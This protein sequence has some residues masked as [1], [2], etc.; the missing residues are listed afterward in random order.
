MML[1]G[2]SYY[3]Y[4]SWKPEYAILIML[5]T[6]ITYLSGLFMGRAV[7]V[8]GKKWILALSLVSNIGILFVFKYFTFLNESLASLFDSLNVRWG[9][10]DF[11][12]L[13][14]VG[15]SFYTFQA[16]S[17]SIDVFR[18]NMK[19]ER[20]FGIYAL[21]VSFFPQL[22]AGPIERSTNLLPQFYEKH[23]FNY[24][25]V[26][27]GLKLMAW[28]YFKKVVVAD[29]LAIVVNKV[30]NSPQN[31]TGLP[32][33][34]ATVFFAFQIYCDF[35]GYSDIAIGAAQVL[36]F[37][38]M[39]NFRRPYLSRTIRE[40]WKRWH[41]SLSSWFKDY[42]Y[43][44]LG[45]NRV[46]YSRH[47]FN[48]FFTFLVS[49]MWHGANWTF[50]VWGAL[51]G[52]YI[53]IESVFG[54]LTGNSEKPRKSRDIAAPFR[55]LLTFCLVDFAWIFFRANSLADA[56]YII[57]H[58]FI[59]IE[60]QLSGFTAFRLVI[61]GL[62]LDK[63]QM[64]GLATSMTILIAVNIVQE[65]ESIRTRLRR[66]PAAIR[67]GLYYLLL[68]WIMTF[69]VFGSQQFIYFQF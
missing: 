21:Y 69:G 62:G 17:Y 13:L 22:V 5:S 2:A 14:P 39:E 30:Y 36:G 26:T 50:F 33:V 67:W 6:V 44:P 47:L 45:G 59:G 54:N 49:G 23:G 29:G 63:V 51:H 66:S 40:F 9:I 7:G 10:P 12:L 65:R 48:L 24:E 61:S 35:S 41:I 43:I 11:K 4:M 31:Y 3:F 8:R 57:G 20:N 58:L 15:I 34:I 16:L 68:I 32:L 19:P 18:G 42:L 53:I 38:L 37:R 25:R 56:I 60:T 28:G 64:I 27:D 1:L 46:T 52:F 55:I